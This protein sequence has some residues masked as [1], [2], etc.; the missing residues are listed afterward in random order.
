MLHLSQQDNQFPFL[1]PPSLPARR[2]AHVL[3]HHICSMQCRSLPALER[4]PPAVIFLCCPCQA[5]DRRICSA[6]RADYYG[7]TANL[8][9]RICQ[10]AH[11]G[12]IL[13]EGG[14]GFTQKLHWETSLQDMYSA[15]LPV[16]TDPSG[17]VTEEDIELKFLGFYMLKVSSN[18]LVNSRIHQS[19]L[20]SLYQ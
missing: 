15:V 19:V 12:Q 6:G 7:S 2:T 11:P 4:R 10:Q 5:A 14:G 20:C 3:Q 8:A 18:S 1:A 9:A 16:D 13:V 17:L